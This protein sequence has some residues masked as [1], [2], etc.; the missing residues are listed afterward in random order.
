[1]LLKGPEIAKHNSEKSCWVIIHKKAYDV[2][3]FLS[4]HPG[5]SEIILKFAVSIHF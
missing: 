3:E 1:M 2:T 5:G 4:N